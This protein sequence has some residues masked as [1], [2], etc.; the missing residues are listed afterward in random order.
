[1][2]AAV[3]GNHWKVICSLTIL[4]LVEEIREIKDCKNTM[5]YLYNFLRQASN[6]EIWTEYDIVVAYFCLAFILNSNFWP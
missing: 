6:D 2:V 3:S 5:E 1:M 4:T